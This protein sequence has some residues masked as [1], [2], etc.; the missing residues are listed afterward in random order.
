MS[1]LLIGGVVAF[2]LSLALT[3]RVAAFFLRKRLGQPIHDDMSIE[4]QVKQGTPTMGGVVVI[5]AATIGYLVAHI[6]TDG[7]PT[8][9]GLLVLLLLIGLGGVGFLDDF[10]KITRGRNLG[11]RGRSKLIGQT[12]VAVLF[13]ILA[14]LRPDA[15][16][17]TPASTYLSFARDIPAVQLGAIVFVIWALFMVS[18][19]SNG[20]N[21]LDGLDGL[22]IGTCVLVFAGYTAIGLFQSGQTCAAAEVPGCYEVRDPFDL[23]VLAFTL[24]LACAGFLWWNCNPARI[25]M[26]DT[27]ALG[28]GGAVAGMAVLTRTEL[29]L[30][31]VGGLYVAAN[32][33]VILQRGYFKLTRRLTGIPKRMFLSSPLQFHFQHKGWQEITIVVRFWIICGA[34][35][36]T[37]VGIFLAEWLGL[38]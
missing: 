9:S 16:G 3:P 18:A 25:F 15:R 11:L 35:V 38:A 14:L 10:L 12:V 28:L 36:A 37:G 5:G 19:T 4:H 21:L 26:G 22:A 29:L 34:L 8:L 17:L 1:G 33:S 23:A 20:V 24:S 13:A 31:I 30:V 27:G 2:A 32:A 7:G 6:G